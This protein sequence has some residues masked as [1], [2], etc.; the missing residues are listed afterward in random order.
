MSS[1]FSDLGKDITSM[2]SCILGFTT[3]EYVDDI[4]FAYMSIFTPGQPPAVKFDYEK[5]ILDKMHD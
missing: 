4:I 3:N 2:I 1:Y 5:F